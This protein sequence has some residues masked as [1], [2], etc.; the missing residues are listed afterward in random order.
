MQSFLSDPLKSYKTSF[1]ACCWDKVAKYR[2]FVI[3]KVCVN[4][5]YYKRRHWK[6]VHFDD[7]IHAAVYVQVIAVALAWKVFLKIVH[8][9][10]QNFQD[11]LANA[12]DGNP[13]TLSSN[14]PVCNTSFPIHVTTEWN[15]LRPGTIYRHPCW[16][17]NRKENGWW[18]RRQPQSAQK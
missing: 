1:C 12:P 8:R 18:D 2:T 16:W 15:P 5:I 7:V 17:N 11:C 9:S 4:F 3:L 14:L 6:H 10:S 13:S